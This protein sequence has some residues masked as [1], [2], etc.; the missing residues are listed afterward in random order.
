MKGDLHGN[1]T[2]LIRG[3]ITLVF[4]LIQSIPREDTLK[5]P[6][7]LILNDPASGHGCRKCTKTLWEEGKTQ[8]IDTKEAQG[9]I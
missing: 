4:L 1:K 7:N 6:W 3:M 2:L 5:E 8:E 9:D